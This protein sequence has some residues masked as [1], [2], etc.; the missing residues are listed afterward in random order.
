MARVLLLA[1]T[2]GYQTRAFAA[3]A[4]RLGV[5]LVYATDRCGVLTDPWRD[6]AVAIRFDDVAGA[7]ATIVERAVNSPLDGVI[8]VGDQPTRV[9]AMVC[10][11]L[12]LSE[13]MRMAISRGKFR[14]G[15]ILMLVSLVLRFVKKQMPGWRL[16]N[17][18]KQK[19]RRLW[20][21]WMR[22]MIWYWHCGSLKSDRN[23]KYRLMML[24]GCLKPITV[25]GSCCLR[26]ISM[27]LL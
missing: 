18:I 10:Q 19:F 8:A 23:M 25:N 15:L 11:Q 2:T 5:E 6:D 24:F 21:L 13:W 20:M 14:L 3:A 17:F 7:V 12:S 26:K 1:T 9:A 16:K 22:I 27:M 4:D